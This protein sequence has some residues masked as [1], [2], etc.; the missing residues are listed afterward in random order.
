M[1]QQSKALNAR[2][3]R[4]YF[5]ISLLMQSQSYEYVIRAVIL[6]LYFAEAYWKPLDMNFIF[7]Q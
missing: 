7:V 3:A 5:C 2:A 1:W 4:W 6:Y